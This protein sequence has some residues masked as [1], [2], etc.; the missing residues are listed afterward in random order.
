MLLG[1]EVLDFGYHDIR[2]FL[3]DCVKV[4]RVSALRQ[5]CSGDFV[6]G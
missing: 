3:E 1:H 4:V 6:L 2:Y 5:G